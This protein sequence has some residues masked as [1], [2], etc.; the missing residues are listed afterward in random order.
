MELAIRVQILDEYVLVSFHANSLKK[1]INLSA[2][3]QNMG[4]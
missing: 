1:S 2:L 4:N 3:R